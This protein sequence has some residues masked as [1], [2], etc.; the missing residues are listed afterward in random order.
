MTYLTQVNKRKPSHSVNF[1]IAHDGFTLYDLVSY[2]QKVV[3]GFYVVFVPFVYHS[4]Q[5]AMLLLCVCPL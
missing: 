4:S 5:L 1:V 3:P 2:N